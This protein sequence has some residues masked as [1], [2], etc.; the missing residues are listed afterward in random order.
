V[1]SWKGRVATSCPAAATPMMTLVP[2]PRCAA[3]SAAR[4]TCELSNPVVWA[5]SYY[6]QHSRYLCVADALK[7]ICKESLLEIM[8]DEIELTE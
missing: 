1:T 4:I 2:Q 7:R 8:N 3:S 5:A 6:V